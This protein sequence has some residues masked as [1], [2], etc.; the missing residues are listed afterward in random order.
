M[1]TQAVRPLLK[2]AWELSLSNTKHGKFSSNVGL[3]NKPVFSVYLNNVIVDRLEGKE[4][5]Q[6]DPEC[7][8][9]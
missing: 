2:M 5:D 3:I 6:N 4:A 7:K 1:R 8:R 9:K